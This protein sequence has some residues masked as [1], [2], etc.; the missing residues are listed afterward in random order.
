MLLDEKAL[1]THLQRQKNS[2][3]ME[4]FIRA[5]MSRQELAEINQQRKYIHTKCL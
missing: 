1:H 3:I 2:H 4:Y 5:G